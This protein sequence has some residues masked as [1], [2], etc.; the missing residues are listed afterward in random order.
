[1]AGPLRAPRRKTLNGLFALSGNRCAFPDC[2]TPFWDAATGTV[3][4][5]VAHIRGKS[6]GSAR[7]DPGLADEEKH[8]ITNLIVLCKKHHQVVD[9]D[10]GT[11]S[12]ERLTEMKRA[13]E[14]DSV[15]ASAETTIRALQS[16]LEQEGR[17][18]EA[19]SAGLNGLTDAVAK[20]FD[21]QIIKDLPVSSVF[22]WGGKYEANSCVP[23]WVLRHYGGAGVGSV[24]FRYRSQRTNALV[25]WQRRPLDPHPLGAR[26]TLSAELDLT[27]DPAPLDDW[28]ELG[29]DDIG[30]EVTFQYAGAWWLRRFRM[31]AEIGTKLRQVAD[32]TE[33]LVVRLPLG[34][35]P[36][37]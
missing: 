21:A 17:Q 32:G 1:M 16:F 35:W 3:L 2:Q 36:Q 11:Y 15:E 14:S 27:S 12:V 31:P 22:S 24:N 7:H 8:G 18:A 28:P 37:A 25:P 23:G 30:L 26:A 33:S 9:G 13:S 20:G 4:G 6:L 29:P 19:L 10:E 34:M 5:D